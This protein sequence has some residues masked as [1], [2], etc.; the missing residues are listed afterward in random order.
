M[1]DSSTPGAGASDTSDSARFGARALL[2]G[3]AIGLVAVP[4]SLLLIMVEGRWAPLLRIDHGAR[5]ALHA[6]AVDEAAFV[7]AMKIVSTVGSARIYVPLFAVIAA[8]LAW[9]GLRRLAVFVVVTML[10]SWLLNALVKVAVD[11]ARPTLPD[12]IAHASGM[13][14]PSGHAQSATVA[15]SVLLLV[16]LPALRDRAARRR[17]AVVAAGVWVIAVAFSRVAL[18]V[19]YVS[20]VLAGAVLGAAWVGAT[21]AL[22]SVWRLERGQ[23]AVEPAQG[24]EPEH[25]ARLG[26]GRPLR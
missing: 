21:T 16:F 6:V 2:A 1:L 10:G 5:D 13:S 25:A 17:I 26:T 15:V 14:F 19:H 22:F 11:R 12:P 8:W 20:D 24:L 9:R 18:G 3:V 7:T 23:P 4:F